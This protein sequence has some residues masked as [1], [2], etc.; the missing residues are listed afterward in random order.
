VADIPDAGRVSRRSLLIGGAGAA[1]VIAA[2]AGGL[3]IEIHRHPGLRKRIFGCGTTP[4]IP[5]S[6]YQLTTGTIRSVAMKTT[7]PWEVAM[8]PVAQRSGTLSLVAVLPGAGGNQHEFVSGNGLPGYATAAHLTLCFVSPGDVGSSYYHPR[9]DGSDYLA[10]ITDELIPTIEGRFGV[11][12]SRAQRAAYGSS[13]GGFGALLL[14]QQR[15]DLICAAVGA[16]PAV[17]PSYHAAITGHPHTFDSAADW[18]RWGLWSHLNTLDQVP[19]RI[20]CG[21]ADPFVATARELLHRIPDA[22]GGISSGCHN[23][24][25][26]RRHAAAELTFLTRHLAP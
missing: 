19:V 22:V 15:P 14:A 20:D 10:F 1:A 25:F 16:S 18:E 9:S 5:P 6:S 11:G 17:F 4:P 8:P 13:M 26:W 7:I 2:G 23:A 21:D 3:D 24:G 12:G